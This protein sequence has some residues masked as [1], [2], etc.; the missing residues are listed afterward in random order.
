MIY[1]LYMYNV[2]A[3]RKLE[4]IPF[5]TVACMFYTFCYFL[6]WI[7]WTIRIQTVHRKTWSFDLHFLIIVSFQFARLFTIGWGG[8]SK[9]ETHSRKSKKFI[10]LHLDWLCTGWRVRVCVCT[11]LPSVVVASVFLCLPHLQSYTI[12]FWFFRCSV[13]SFFHHLHLQLLI[14]FVCSLPWSVIIH[15]ITY[16]K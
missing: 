15:E 6:L 10:H 2:Q 13:R 1:K 3:A 7:P 8:G 5:W 11:I 16:V 4:S 9:N 14:P 12:P